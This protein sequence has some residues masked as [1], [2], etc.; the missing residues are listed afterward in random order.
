MKKEKN[1]RW[2]AQTQFEGRNTNLIEKK[3]KK[4]REA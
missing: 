3:N 1:V 2:Y 4:Y